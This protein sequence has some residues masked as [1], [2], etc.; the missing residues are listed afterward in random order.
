MGPRPHSVFPYQK[1][2]ILL[3]LGVFQGDTRSSETPKLAALHT[4]F[5]REH[6]RLATELRRLNPHW[7]GDKLYNEARKIVG[8]MVQVGGPEA[9]VNLTEWLPTFENMALRLCPKA[10]ESG[11]LGCISTPGSS[12]D[13]DPIHD[14]SLDSSISSSNGRLRLPHLAQ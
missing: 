2:L 7:S 10:A 6:N 9:S 12:M 13:G 5:V 14:I 8:A 11:C 1:S 4:L 3:N